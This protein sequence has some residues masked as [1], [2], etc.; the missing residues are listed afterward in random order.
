[1]ESSFCTRIFCISDDTFSGF[2]ST[3]DISHIR[4]LDEIVNEIKYKLYFMLKEMDLDI[5]CKL[6][7][8]KKFHIHDVTL[9]HIFFSDPQKVFYIC[10]H[11]DE[12]GTA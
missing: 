11:C 9:D 10:S 6:L 8:Q 12:K 3:I 2:K 5:L 4:N 7:D 1:M